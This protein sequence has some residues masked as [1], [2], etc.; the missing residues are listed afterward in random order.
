MEVIDGTKFV[1]CFTLHT[2]YDNDCVKVV[3]NKG[4]SYRLPASTILQMVNEFMFTVEEKR[5]HKYLVDAMSK[6]IYQADKND[7][8]VL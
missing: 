7:K 3:D 2:M 4:K 8:D 1:E 5:V 6:D